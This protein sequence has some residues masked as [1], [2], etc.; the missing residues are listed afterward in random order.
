MIHPEEMSILVNRLIESL[1]GNA[2]SLPRRLTLYGNDGAF[3]S[4][5]KTGSVKSLLRSNRRMKCCFLRSE[6]QTSKFNV[7][8]LM[9]DVQS[10]CN[11]SVALI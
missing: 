11:Q 4:N 1:E 7:Q 3:P 10:D 8:R 9:F 6:H 2:L 5:F